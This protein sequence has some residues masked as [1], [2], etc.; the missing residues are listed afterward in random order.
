[1]STLEKTRD[2]NV[3]EEIVLDP[4][5]VINQKL[6]NTA[7]T[8]ITIVI[9]FVTLN[10]PRLVLNLVEYFLIDTIHDSTCPCDQTPVWVSVLARISHLFLAINS[11]I[12]FL[13][14][15]SVEKNFKA[16]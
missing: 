11:S 9:A 16:S 5:S 14:Y 15:Y 1:M 13:I 2:V 8:L 7:I 12:N 4:D 10:L 6:G 3:R